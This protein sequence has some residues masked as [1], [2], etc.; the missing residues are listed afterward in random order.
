M[1]GIDELSTTARSVLAALGG[2][3]VSIGQDGRGSGLVIS[4]GKVLTNSHNL[5]DRTTLVTFADGSTRFIKDTINLKVYQAI[6]TRAGCGPTSA[7]RAA[8]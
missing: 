2:A 1:S 8:A 3:I 5:R 6:C 7:R 4:A